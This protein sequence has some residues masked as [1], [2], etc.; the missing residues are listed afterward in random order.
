[1]RVVRCSTVVVLA[2][3]V[4]CGSETADTAAAPE[5]S[6][7]PVTDATPITDERN[8]VVAWREGVD[9][10]WDAYA[11]FTVT[12][13][14]GCLVLE[15]PST[16]YQ[17]LSIW[18]AGTSWDTTASAVVLPDGAR[19]HDGDTIAIGGGGIPLDQADDNGVDSRALADDGLARLQ[20]CSAEHG[21]LDVWLFDSTGTIER[22]S[23]DQLDT[24]TATS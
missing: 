1:M 10:D 6:A 5:S 24:T 8:P 12:I 19:L 23:V 7:P 9:Q 2:A 3:P 15:S 17:T 4:G 16:R 21:G 11:V 22:A 14:D 18:P 20:A 13:D